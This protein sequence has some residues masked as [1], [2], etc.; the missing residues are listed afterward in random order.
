MKIETLDW[1]KKNNKLLFVLK[2]SNEAFANLI[3]RFAVDE[4]P[5]LAIDEVEF[6]DNS[7]ALYDEIIAHRL[8]LIPIKTD[9]KSYELPENCSCQGEG[10]AKCQLKIVLKTG[11]RGLVLAS[12]AQSKDPKC[13]FVYP[14]MP[15]VKLSAKQKLEL[16]ATAILGKGKK[17]AKWSPGL[18][19]YM[20]KPE[21]E[22][23]A[24]KISDEDKQRLSN[25]D[26]KAF[27]LSGSKLK[28]NHQ[29]FIQSPNFEACL[30]ILEKNQIPIVYQNNFVFHIESWGQHDPKKIVETAADMLTNQLD[31]LAKLL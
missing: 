17:H 10:C 8:G 25:L 31:E 24:K 27:I 21:V 22:F 4:V 9:L 7:S 26:K 16:V 13:K 28:F 14:N 23:D 15:I 3:R 30:E 19:F 6:R 11:K 12:D 5:T 20:H 1:D 18:I 29:E 2:D